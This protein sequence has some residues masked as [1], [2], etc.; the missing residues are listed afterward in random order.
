MLSLWLQRL[1]STVWSGDAFRADPVPQQ[2]GCPLAGSRTRNGNCQQRE[3]NL[4]GALAPRTARPQQK[5]ATS[6]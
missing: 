3:P 2:D 5:G 6:F 4:A 1:H